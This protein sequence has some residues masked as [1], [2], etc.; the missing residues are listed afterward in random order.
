MN[1]SELRDRTRQLLGRLKHTA[2]VESDM[3][4][5]LEP[6]TCVLML[7]DSEL[8]NLADGR[9]TPVVGADD[10]A[11]RLASVEAPAGYSDG[12][13]EPPAAQDIAAAAQRLLSGAL[14]GRAPEQPLNVLLLL[15]PAECLFSSASLPGVAPQ[16]VRQALMLQSVELI[17]GYDDELALAVDIEHPETVAW[18]PAARVNALFDA[19]AEH[20]L[21]LAGIQPRPFF[22]LSQLMA[23]QS[24]P[25]IAVHDQDAEHLATL[26]IEDGKV[27]TALQTARADLDTPELREQWQQ[28]VS[29]ADH[30]E[31]RMM[32][33]GRRYFEWTEPRLAELLRHLSPRY[34]FVPPGALAARHH[35]N[36]GKL[37][38]TAAVLAAG[39]LLVCGLPFLIQTARLWMLESELEAVAAQAVDARADQAV[40]RDFESQW[41]AIAEFPRQDVAEVMLALQDTLNPAVL[42][43]L[44]ISEGR[45]SIEGDS[46]DPQNL[47]EMLARDPRFTEVD[48]ARATNNNR[49]YIDLRLT[50]VNFPAYHA[51]YFP[52]RR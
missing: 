35:I 18:L 37:R 36:K 28:S 19:F 33:S 42:G 15:P 46:P 11:A 21:F 44:E 50:T 3:A 24:R 41:G 31:A 1:L 52:E 40:V 10:R 5:L 17:P 20:H 23:E 39:L 16:A 9:S 22:L 25:S 47:L 2:N 29:A 48:F 12:R 32:D 26:I 8:I 6:V 49:Y 4:Q 34:V 38:G 51:W 43:A 27:V 13:D 7:F 14:A 45:I 30:T